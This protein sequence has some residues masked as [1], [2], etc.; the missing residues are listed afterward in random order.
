M[1]WKP[2]SQPV[3]T[4]EDGGVPEFQSQPVVTARLVWP[5]PS[6]SLFQRLEST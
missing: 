6:G 4:V 1:K 5:R 2:R 3:D